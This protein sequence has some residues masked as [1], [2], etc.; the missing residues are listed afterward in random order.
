MYAA[1]KGVNNH[2]GNVAAHGIAAG[3]DAAQAAAST[4]WRAL[5]LAV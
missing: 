3:S 1:S 2:G 4:A 5:A